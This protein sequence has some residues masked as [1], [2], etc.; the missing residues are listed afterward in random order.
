MYQ[1]EHVLQS[2]S[3][4]V[5]IGKLAKIPL[6]SQPGT[7]WEYSVSMDI[8]GYIVEKFRVDRCQISCR[9]IYSGPSK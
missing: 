9:S 3:L 8:Q 2:Q 1:D 6:L 7:R 4:E 5:M